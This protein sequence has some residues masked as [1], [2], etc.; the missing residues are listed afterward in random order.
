M[1]LDI[2][3][4]I[5]PAVDDGA[6]NVDDTLSLLE[7]MR[8]QGITHVIATPHFYPNDDTIE[9]FKTRVAH[10]V[11]I[12]NKRHTTVPDIIIGC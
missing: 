7:M 10:A 9:E 6:K 2:H 4:H 1:L 3:S 5:L 11:S 8:S 12:L